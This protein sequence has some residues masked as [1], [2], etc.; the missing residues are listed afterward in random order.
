MR[1]LTRFPILRFHSRSGLHEKA[2]AGIR[3]LSIDEK[4]VLGNIHPQ[5]E[6]QPH[7]AELFLYRS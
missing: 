6:S 2:S 4:H 5:A 3:R 1:L 7:D